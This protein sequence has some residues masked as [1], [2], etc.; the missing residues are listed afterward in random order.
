MF[1]RA[2]ALSDD[3]LAAYRTRLDAIGP[4]TVDAGR[5]HATIC[6]ECPA[7][8]QSDWGPLELQFATIADDDSVTIDPDEE[9]FRLYE[10][11]VSR[12][13]EFLAQV[14]A[15]C[16][17]Y[18]AECGTLEDG[19]VRVIREDGTGDED[20]TASYR[21][22]VHVGFSDDEHTAYSEYEPGNDRFGPLQG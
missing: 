9:M 11:F 3:F 17:D 15:I 8:L 4:W 5:D 13:D 21:L 1:G 14:T 16:A 10:L 18:P 2:N 20:G 19:E 6:W 12:R 7:A 22:S